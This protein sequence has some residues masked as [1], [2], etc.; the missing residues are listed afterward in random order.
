M[1]RTSAPTPPPHDWH[2]RD[3]AEVARAHGVDPQLGL[4]LQEIESRTRRHGRNELPS[5][6]PRSVAALV[7]EQFRDLMIVVLI[8]AAVISGVLGDW[9]DT[10]VI[11]IIIVLDAVIANSDGPVSNSPLPEPGNGGGGGSLSA[12]RAPGRN[13]E[14]GAVDESA[15]AARNAAIPTAATS[16]RM[17]HPSIVD[18][19]GIA[20]R[21]RKP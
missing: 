16:R 19:A 9:V 15:Q 11:A 13:R 4:D 21:R 14:V 1:P 10:L 8:A 17:R 12:T 20:R 2:L 3:A 6:P 7:A 5:A 18:G